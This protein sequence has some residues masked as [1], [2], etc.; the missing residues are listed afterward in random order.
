MM[1]Y[2][3]CNQNQ[4]NIVTVDNLLTYCHKNEM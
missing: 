1:H 4:T 3:F 2:A